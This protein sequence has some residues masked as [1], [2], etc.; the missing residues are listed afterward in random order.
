M[1][2]T[3]VR[4]DRHGRYVLGD[5]RIYRPEHPRGYEHLRD[6]TDLPVGTE[7]LLGATSTVG[8]LKAGDRLEVWHSHGCYFGAGGKR[9]PTDQ[10]YRPG[11]PSRWAKPVRR[12]TGGIDPLP[13]PA[14]VR[15]V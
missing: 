5:G 8:R 4:E 15:R 7:V 14:A 11:D 9:L 10:L 13:T 3:K 12:D 2:K 1:P 6:G